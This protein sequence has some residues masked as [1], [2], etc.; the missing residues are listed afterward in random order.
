MVE[1]STGVSPPNSVT[2]N[3]FAYTI[4]IVDDRDADAGDVPITHTLGERVHIIRLP[5]DAARRPKHPL[6]ATGMRATLDVWACAGP[7]SDATT[8]TKPKETLMRCGS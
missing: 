2:P 4:E 3:P 8:I 5:S 7:K 6:D 1:V